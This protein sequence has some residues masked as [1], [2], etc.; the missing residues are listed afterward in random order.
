M[1]RY[2]A[3]LYLVVFYRGNPSD[4]HAYMVVSAEDELTCQRWVREAYP[5]D[6]QFICIHEDEIA[7]ID[8]KAAFKAL[9]DDHII[10]I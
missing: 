1:A 10:E 4:S 9:L 6:D 2:G 5:D 3:N 7:N 8:D